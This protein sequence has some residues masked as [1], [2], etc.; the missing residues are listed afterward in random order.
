M[1]VFFSSLVKKK[2]RIRDEAESLTLFHCLLRVEALKEYK[3]PVQAIT[4]LMN[5]L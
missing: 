1:H 4:N 3:N 5:S 2:K